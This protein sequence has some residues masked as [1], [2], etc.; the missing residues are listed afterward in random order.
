MA[1]GP[2]VIRREPARAAE[3]F[4]CFLVFCHDGTRAKLCSCL[5]TGDPWRARPAW[6]DREKFMEVQF[7]GAELSRTLLV[8]EISR[9]RLPQPL[10]Q[11][12]LA[13]WLA[14]DEGFTGRA[15]LVGQHLQ[16]VTGG[17][18]NGRPG[19][20]SRARSASSQPLMPPGMTMSVK[21][22]WMPGLSLS[23]N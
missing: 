16:R 8:H 18:D 4:R 17:E 23:L 10:R 20:I 22:I 9:Q 7:A 19:L 12:C 14:Q 13:V 11:F 5:L 21:S 2:Q 1:K 6:I 3:R 15:A